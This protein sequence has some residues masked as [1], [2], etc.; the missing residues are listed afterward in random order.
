M[1][2][3]TFTEIQWKADTEVPEF[4][5][6]QKWLYADRSRSSTTPRS[7]STASSPSAGSRGFVDLEG[8]PDEELKK[9]RDKMEQ[10][11][12][13]APRTRRRLLRRHRSK[14]STTSASCCGGGSTGF[15]TAGAHEAKIRVEDAV[16]AT[17]P[18]RVRSQACA[19]SSPAASRRRI[20][21]QNGIRDDLTLA[22]LLCTSLVLLGHLPLLPALRP[23]VGDRRAGGAGPAARADASPRSRSTTSTS[24]PRSSSRSSSAT[25]STRRSSCSARYGEERRRGQAG[26]A[27]ADDGDDRRRCVGIVAAM[28][29]ASDRLRLPAPDQLPRLQ[30]V[31][32]PR[33]RRHA[34]RLVS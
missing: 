1:V 10:Q 3:A 30:P 15:A 24:T 7:C 19:S 31:R 13:R 16:H 25:A 12:P 21:E 8:D 34:A 26:G 23:L 33:R 28:A 32:P 17:E 20:D 14:A 22:T 18:G 27:G 5:R 9:L 11:L 29:A 4:A 6:K 2:P